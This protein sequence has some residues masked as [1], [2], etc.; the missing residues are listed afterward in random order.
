M[1]STKIKIVTRL[2]APLVGVPFLAG[3]RVFLFSEKSQSALEPTQP[4]M[5][6]GLFPRV[7]QLGSEDDHSSP[8]SAEVES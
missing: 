1:S 3:A 4:P 5:G 8:S 2:R 7:K 6:T